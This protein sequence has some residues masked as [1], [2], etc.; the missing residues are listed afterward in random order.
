MCLRS[1]LKTSK[2]QF[3][4][5]ET[6]DSNFIFRSTCKM[7]SQWIKCVALQTICR[8]VFLCVRDESENAPMHIYFT[9]TQSDAWN[10][11]ISIKV[12]QQYI[13]INV[14]A[15]HFMKLILYMWYVQ[16]VCISHVCMHYICNGNESM[17]S[18]QFQNAI[19]QPI[20]TTF[21]SVVMSYILKW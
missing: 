12:N 13:C 1:T 3:T 20:N 14:C 16:R 19:L 21:T 10:E 7:H 5:R 18:K 2:I 17:N 4:F 6:H 8:S 15:N 11:N 9:E